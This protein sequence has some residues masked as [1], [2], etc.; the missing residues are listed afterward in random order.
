[1]QGPY[2][3]LGLD[4]GVLEK[5]FRNWFVLRGSASCLNQTHAMYSTLTCQ[6]PCALASG[7]ISKDPSDGSHTT[8]L[9]TVSSC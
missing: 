5:W 4:C 6:W 8:L 1:M 2:P 7:L 9:G 3:G